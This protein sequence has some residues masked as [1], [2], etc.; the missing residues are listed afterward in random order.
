MTEQG[1]KDMKEN[2]GWLADEA[3]RILEEHGGKR[4]STWATLGRYDFIAVIEAPD[5][6]TMMQISAKIGA[7]GGA[8]VE[9]LAA[10]PADEFMAGS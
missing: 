10:I 8:H 6:K 7:H 9:T 4:L 2:P 5:D 3:D 1:R